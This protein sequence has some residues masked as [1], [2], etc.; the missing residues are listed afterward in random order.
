VAKDELINKRQLMSMR[1]RI[2]KG[3]YPFNPPFCP[4]ILQAQIHY[5]WIERVELESPP[6]GCL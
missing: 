6:A 2:A 5:W 3:V 1:K 4:K